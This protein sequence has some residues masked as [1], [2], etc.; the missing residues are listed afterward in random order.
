MEENPR[1]LVCYQSLN[2]FHTSQGSKILRDRLSTRSTSQSWL[3]TQKITQERH[4]SFT[5]NKSRV[6]SW[7]GILNGENLKT[8]PTETMKM[9]RNLNEKDLVLGI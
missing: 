4:T 3:D 2:A 5:A 6:S 1:S 8:D 9:F 7:V